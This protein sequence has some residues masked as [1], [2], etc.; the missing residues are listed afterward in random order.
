MPG[1]ISVI[2]ASGKPA[3]GQDR[4]INLI[5]CGAFAEGYVDGVAE[6]LSAVAGHR[7]GAEP[8]HW[9]GLRS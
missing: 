1:T 4:L 9:A 2:E 3:A 8:E 6:G 7:S 5:R